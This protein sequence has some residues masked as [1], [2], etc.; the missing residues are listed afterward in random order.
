MNTPVQRS[1]F[2]DDFLIR[3]LGE[4]AY[5]PD[6]AICE[7]V[8][9]AWDAGA[10]TVQI[11]IPSDIGGI[12]AVE[13]DGVG[14]NEEL[15]RSRWMRLGYQRI[16]HQGE[17]AEFPK[18]RIA[19][20]RKAYGRNGQGR[21]ALLCF[22]NKYSVDTLRD[23]ETQAFRF[24]VQPS[25]NESPFVLTETISIDR[26]ARGTRLWTTVEK[27][28]PIA[29]RIT[30]AISLAFLSDPTFTI[31][32]NEQ[33]ITFDAFDVAHK[34][35]V[36]IP[37]G[38]CTVKF[39]RL[40][41]GKKGRTGV[42]FWV[43][44]RLVGQP[45]YQLF[46]T[47]LIDGRSTAARN[48]FVIVQSDDLFEHVK[49]DWSGFTRTDQF[50]DVADCIAS[51]VSKI[52]A[53]LNADA[54]DE[55]K[56][57]AYIENRNG[58]RT[59]TPLGK[60]EVKEFVDGFVDRV[61]GIS[62][63]ILA[64]GIAAAVNLEQSR[65]GHTLLQKLASIPESDVDSLSRLLS[66]WTIKDAMLVLDELGRRSATVEAIR[67]LNGDPSAD[68]LHTMHPL[69]AQSRWLFG[70]EFDSPHFLSNTSI[71]S[72]AERVFKK[73]IDHSQIANPRQRPD[74]VFI[75]D[76]TIGITAVNRFDSDAEI[77]VL[78]R[79]LLIELKRGDTKIELKHVQQA[80]QYIQDLLSCGLLDGAPHI[81]AFVVGH[82]VD[83]RLQAVTKIGDPETARIQATTFD[84]L[85]RT[86][87][88]RLFGLSSALQG[89][90]KDTPAA[91]LLDSILGT[92][93][94]SLFA[95]VEGGDPASNM[96][97]K[98]RARKPRR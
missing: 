84:T 73:K 53:R 22:A 78:D 1:L 54:I 31:V 6:T 48:H 75:R 10:S 14:L 44:N 33:H 98:Q 63:D 26:T 83:N 35:S 97:P 28:L 94:P 56:K 59:L 57:I 77:A 65:S 34:E 20:K 72:A 9:N 82:R 46:G 64:A 24:T 95:N 86:A 18:E 5:R 96:A 4:I 47:S 29:S 85:V 27:N 80:E 36:E 19:T 39:L 74:L 32:V 87:E 93:T 55:T 3:T 90:F 16:Q 40:P 68:E 11:T 21:H 17:W 62:S 51:H 43:G 61:P 15:F 58:I 41:Q 60:A 89:H 50:L 13:D 30:D 8:A 88:L 79:L 2:E 67:K 52:A 71:R 23:E 49:P 70:P 25:S 7:L 92:P 66:D 45:G 81:R 91:K 37:G 12:V 76:A 42:A 38:K 69:V